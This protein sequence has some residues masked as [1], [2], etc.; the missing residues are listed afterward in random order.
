[1]GSG[2]GS[3][4]AAED[5]KCFKDGRIKEDV[6]EKVQ[7]CLKEKKFSERFMDVAKRM[8][9][10]KFSEQPEDVQTDM[11]S[12][13][14][15]QYD[16]MAVNSCCQAMPEDRTHESLVEQD[17]VCGAPMCYNGF[18]KTSFLGTVIGAPVGFLLLVVGV[19]LIKRCKNKKT[20]VKQ[21][22]AGGAAVVPA[23]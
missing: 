15:D 11:C 14:H 23:N 17:E 18:T 8:E 10:V 19:F 3:G 20:Q 16:C 5:D 13:L 4:S 22:A 21:D 6:A 1:M 9:R 7:E 2:L 12:I